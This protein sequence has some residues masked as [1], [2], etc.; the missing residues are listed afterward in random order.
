MK[1][2]PAETDAYLFNYATGDLE[3][4]LRS[5]FRTG[6]GVEARTLLEAEHASEQHG[7]ERLDGRVVLH[8]R[9]VEALTTS[10][11]RSEHYRLPFSPRESLRW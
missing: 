10:A 4:Y 8:D 3:G 2:A 11:Y 5:N 6:L 1:K 9:I 7:R